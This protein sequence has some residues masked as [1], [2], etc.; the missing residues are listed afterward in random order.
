MAAVDKVLVVGAGSAGAGVAALLAQ[1]GVAVDIVEIEESIT[2]LGSGITVQGNALRVLEHIGV[3]DKAAALGFG[4]TTTGFRSHDGTLLREMDDIQT[5]GQHLPATM[6]MERTNLARILGEAA[7]DSGATIRFSAT[8]TGLDDDGDQVT[9]K[10]RDGSTGTYDLVIGA[11]GN[12]SSVRKMIGID[13][14]PQPTGM[15]IWRLFTTRP[16]SITRTDLCFDGPAYIAGFCP[17]GPNTMYAYLVEDAADRTGLT[18]EE[19]LEHMRELAE[20]YHGPWDEIRELMTDPRRIHYT[21]FSTHVVEPPWWRGRVVLIGDAAHT[22]PPTLA[23]GAAQALEDALVLS[24]RLIESNGLDSALPEF[25]D[26]RFPRAKT[27]VDVSVQ[28]GQWM[29][30]HDPNADIPGTM[31]RTLGMLCNPA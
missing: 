21:W 11:D 17:T 13:V 25:M 28:L 15:G 31:G 14:E 19:R 24:E 22:C 6:G 3:Y 12:K 23:Q 9:V 16:E 18:P 20:N 4:F 10:F 26:R 27:V 1:G 2:A 5:G 30:D 7:Q 8:V 29:L